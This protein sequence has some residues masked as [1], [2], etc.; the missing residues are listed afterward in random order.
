MRDA[1]MTKRL[2]IAGEGPLAAW[3]ERNRDPLAWATSTALYSAWKSFADQAGEHAGTLK[4]FM[5]QLEV[6]GV[7]RERRKAGRG[8]RGLKLAQL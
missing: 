2:P 5:R 4:W 8:F 1:T 7:V 6:H 3:I